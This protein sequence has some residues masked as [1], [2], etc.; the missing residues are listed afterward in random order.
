MDTLTGATPPTGW[1]AFGAGTAPLR[2]VDGPRGVRAVEHLRAV[3]SELQLAHVRR[4]LSLSMLTGFE[5]FHL[6]KF[7]DRHDAVATK[8]FEQL[9]S[10]ATTLKTVRTRQ[11]RP[12]RP[13]PGRHAPCA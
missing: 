1:P 9:E 3:V 10:W 5:D 4:Q 8:L 12:P 7:E 13:R 6:F 2:R 11:H